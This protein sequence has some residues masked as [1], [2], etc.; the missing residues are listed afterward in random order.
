MYKQSPGRN[1]RSKGIKVK[2]TLQICVL[3]AIC[4]WLIYQIKH[5]YD[6]KK[7]FDE[8]DA[9]ISHKTHVS[10]E[11]LKFGRKDLHPRSEEMN[12]VNKKHD[13]EE[14]EEEETGGGE[15]EVLKNEEEEREEDKKHEEEELE[16]D[17]KTEEKEDEMREG[18][19]DEMD[20]HDQEK[21]EM[22]VE[23]E[24]GFVDEEKER[25]EGDEKDAEDKEGQIENEMSLEDHDQGHEAREEQYRAD[26]ASSAVKHETEGINAENEREVLDNSNE[27]TEM[28]MQEEE[29]KTNN[30]EEIA[31]DQNTTSVKAG[32]VETADKGILPNVA[33]KEEHSE[34]LSLKSEVGNQTTEGHTETNNLSLQNETEAQNGT[35]SVANSEGFNLQTRQET[36]SFADSKNNSSDSIAEADMEDLNSSAT[37][38]IAVSEKV[39][40]PNE[41][42]ETEG[43][44]DAT[45]NEN[46]DTGN[47]TD[48]N[49][50]SDSKTEDADEVHQDPIETSDP[51]MTLEKD[52]RTDLDTLPEI[53]TE[54]SNDEEAAA[55]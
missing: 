31:V 45:Q 1:H 7:S 19:D 24:E 14:V 10:D 11:V 47:V 17:N 2:R 55:E 25:G 20:E 26:D 21:T 8:S 54:G 23:G 51:S 9:K 34:I 33:G 12:I 18:G 13:E 6:K 39:I 32:E 5:S 22:E 38:E 4:F 40:I 41:S 43:N 49:S 42:I 46:S 16:E 44:I 28:E 50:A 53:R 36:N 15:D 29:N 48:E 35:V 52:V 37:K 3:L 27:N 30:A